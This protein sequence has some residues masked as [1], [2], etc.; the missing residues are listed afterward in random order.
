MPEYAGNILFKKDTV[1]M[2]TLTVSSTETFD[3]I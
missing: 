1:R 2:Q 3:Q